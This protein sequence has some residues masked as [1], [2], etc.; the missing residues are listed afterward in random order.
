MSENY[1]KLNK[2]GTKVVVTGKLKFYNILGTI[3]QFAP[4][5]ALLLW[6]F[7]MFTFENEGYAITGWGATLLIFVVIAFR[8]KIKEALTKYDESMGATWKR[9]KAGSVSLTIA[10]VLF[11]VYLFSLNFFVI[12][13][14]FAGS[15]FLS[16]LF[17]A[18]YDNLAVERMALQKMISTENQTKNFEKLKEQYS[19]MKQV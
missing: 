3:T 4:T 12:F 10:V 6:K 13:G 15:T 5:L 8:T 14:L 17:Y 11:F 1:L 9:A 18:P 19:E 7:D 16:L 2:K